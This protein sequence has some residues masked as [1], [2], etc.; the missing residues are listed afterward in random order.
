MYHVSAQDVD[1]RMINVHYY[2]YLQHH[3]DWEPDKRKIIFSIIRAGVVPD[4]ASEE[5][6]VGARHSITKNSVRP[7]HSITRTGMN[8]DT[9]SQELL[10]TQ[11]QQ[12][13]K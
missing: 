9:A 10:R 12:H 5:S 6:G 4:T 8:P 2:Y 7:R 1:E 3:K 11:T 13:K